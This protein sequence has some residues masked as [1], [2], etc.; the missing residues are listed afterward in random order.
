MRS[1]GVVVSTL[2]FE[3]S[4]PSSNLGGTYFCMGIDFNIF[5]ICSLKSDRRGSFL[6]FCDF[7]FIP[8]GKLKK[9]RL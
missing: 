9:V 8:Y 7:Q 4:S 5:E 2:D 1:H 6:A 3:S